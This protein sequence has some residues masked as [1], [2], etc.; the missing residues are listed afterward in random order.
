M[1]KGVKKDAIEGGGW[2]KLMPNFGIND[3][4]K[5]FFNGNDNAYLRSNRFKQKP[6]NLEELKN[7]LQIS[8]T[9]KDKFAFSNSTDSDVIRGIFSYENKNGE[10]YIVCDGDHSQYCYFH[11]Q[12]LC[13]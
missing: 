7:I 10:N 3:N 2:L 4:I 12:N 6:N 13:S 9:N 11:N 8:Q 1:C 5:Y